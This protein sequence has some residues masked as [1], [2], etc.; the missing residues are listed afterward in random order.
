TTTDYV[1]NKVYEN[2]TLKRVLVDGGY[3]ENG[4]YY[5]YQTDHLGNNRVVANQGGTAI[6]KNHYYPFG[7][8]F[9]DKYDD[10]KNQPYK[11]N[12]KELDQMHGLNL[13]DYSARYYESAIGRFT[14]VDPLAEKYYSTSPYAY[15]RNNPIKRIDPNGM[16]DI[17]VTAYP[18]RNQRGFAKLVLT[19][20]KGNERFATTVRVEGSNSIENGF[21][22]RI[23]TRTN[24]DTPTGTYKING[25][26][27]RLSKKDRGAYGPNHILELNYIS[28]EAAG[29]RNGMHAHGGRQERKVN[30]VWIPLENPELMVTQGCIRMLDENIKELKRITDAL[31]IEDEEETGEYFYVNNNLVYIGNDEYTTD[32]LYFLRRNEEQKVEAA[33]YRAWLKTSENIENSYNYSVYGK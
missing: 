1:G 24:A 19:D 31:E 18:D 14:T 17:T 27:M 8:A 33:W 16:W 9:A 6:Q 32:R 4:V 23:R 13:Y 25:W 21:N 5:F 3:I 22:K 26:S 29:L 10:G 20:R 7:T 28:G 12:G 11:Y 2:G 15:V 30:G